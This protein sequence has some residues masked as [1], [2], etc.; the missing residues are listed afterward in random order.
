MA[1]RQVAHL[2]IQKR[3][4]FGPDT[5]ITRSLCRRSRTTDD[6]MNLTGEESE[7]TCKFCLKLMTS[8]KRNPASQR[9][10]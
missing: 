4:M 3:G 6:G 7:V 5:M 2:S 8:A 1:N 10:G 9:I